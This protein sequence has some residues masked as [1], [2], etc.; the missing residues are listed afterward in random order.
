MDDSNRVIVEAWNTVLF[1][2]FFRFKH[3]IVDGLS[4]HSD[5]ALERCQYGPGQRV[6]DVRGTA[7]GAA[8]S[9]AC[10]ADARGCRYAVAR[11]SPDVRGGRKSRRH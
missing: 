11:Q 6:L 2:K 9:E 8:R 5:A 7:R 4:L 3:L 10:A 1:E